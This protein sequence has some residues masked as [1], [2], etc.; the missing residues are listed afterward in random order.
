MAQGQRATKHLPETL[1]SPLQDI[2]AQVKSVLSFSVM[3]A[4]LRPHGLEHSRFLCPWNSPGKNTGVG[5]HS[6]LQGIFT[7]QGFVTV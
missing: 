3:S 5:S 1:F 7:T 4:S 2:W 6:L